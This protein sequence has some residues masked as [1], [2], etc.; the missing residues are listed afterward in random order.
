MFPRSALYSYAS[1]LIFWNAI[2]RP[3]V[4]TRLPF[5]FV[6]DLP[7]C[8]LPNW[9]EL[10]LLGPLCVQRMIADA[11]TARASWLYTY[12]LTAD[13]RFGVF[14]RREWIG[15][16]ARRFHKSVL[17]RLSV[18]HVRLL[19]A[20]YIDYL[21]QLLLSW[22]EDSPP[23]E[24]LLVFICLC[25][26]IAQFYADLCRRFGYKEARAIVAQE[27]VT[28]LGPQAPALTVPAAR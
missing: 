22:P 14:E 15:I 11:V 23:A 2:W 16:T 6:D 13:A 21:A 10:R 17:Q 12:H 27:I 7:P 24:K 19:L 28:A 1:C 9:P 3:F 20:C 26:R 25:S 18:D 5:T 4:K 8:Q